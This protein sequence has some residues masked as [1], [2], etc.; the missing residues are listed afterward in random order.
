MDRCSPDCE[1]LV[2]TPSWTCLSTDTLTTSESPTRIAVIIVPLPLW[3]PSDAILS[4][5][6]KIA[7]LRSAETLMFPR[8]TFPCATSCKYRAIPDRHDG[9]RIVNPHQEGNHA[10]CDHDGHS[11][12][13]LHRH[14]PRA[15]GGPGQEDPVRAT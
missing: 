12:R 8:R 2:P 4:A 6:E 15:D 10:N 13:A 11:G 5:K 1:P 7:A 14:R 9:R 3:Y